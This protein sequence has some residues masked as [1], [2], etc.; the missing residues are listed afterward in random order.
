MGVVAGY[1]GIRTL[2]DGISSGTVHARLKGSLRSRGQSAVDASTGAWASVSFKR[3]PLHA[4]V[5]YDRVLVGK[6]AMARVQEVVPN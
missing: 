3:S 1:Q 2:F 6:V 5:P 4:K